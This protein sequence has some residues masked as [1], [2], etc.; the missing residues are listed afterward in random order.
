MTDAP[1]GRAKKKQQDVSTNRP[2]QRSGDSSDQQ[3]FLTQPVVLVLVPVLNAWDLF[4]L[5]LSTIILINMLYCIV[6]GLFQLCFL[7]SPL[8]LL[9]K[10]K[11]SY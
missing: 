7:S 8:G 3:T 10:S 11:R 5:T 2:G 9:R 6:I 4:L 1:H